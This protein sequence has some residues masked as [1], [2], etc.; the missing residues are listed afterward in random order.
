MKT[1]LTVASVI[2]VLVSTTAT[3]NTSS[4][5]GSAGTVATN[6]CTFFGVTAG[7]L[8]RTG[9]VWATTTVGTISVRSRGQAKVY[10]ESDNILRDNSGE[11]VSPQI[12][13]TV[14][15]TTGGITSRI[16]KRSGTE[17]ITSTRMEVDSLTSDGAA[18]TVFN[19]GGSATMTSANGATGDNNP[20]NWLTNDATYT[21]SHT[22]TCEQ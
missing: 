14:D 22:A 3:A 17:S 12:T 2:A 5:S 8:S 10:V 13:A 4:W 7:A 18:L 1:L 15:Y 21:I 6:G 11:A 9:V 20:L 16:F 19:M